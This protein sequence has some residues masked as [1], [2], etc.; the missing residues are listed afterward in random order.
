MET[1]AIFVNLV[2]RVRDDLGQL[3]MRRSQPSPSHTKVAVGQEIRT[4]ANDRFGWKAV[5]TQKSPAVWI[6]RGLIGCYLDVTC[7]GCVADDG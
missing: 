6:G 4:T 2:T 5:I 3:T 7:F 1:G